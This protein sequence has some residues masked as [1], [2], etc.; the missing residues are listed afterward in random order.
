MSCK[1]YILTH[2]YRYGWEVYDILY[3]KPTNSNEYMSIV[4]KG[5]YAS[6]SYLDENKVFDSGNL[7][8]VMGRFL[9]ETI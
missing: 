7:E 4:G 2:T 3:T 9:L 6:W 1:R 5:S 8:E